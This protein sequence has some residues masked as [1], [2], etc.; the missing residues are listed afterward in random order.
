MKTIPIVCAM[1]MAL[2]LLSGCGDSGDKVKITPPPSSQSG[3]T[4]TQAG[5][6]TAV[7]VSTDTGA[8]TSTGTATGTGLPP[9]PPKEDWGTREKLGTGRQ[10]IVIPKGW[11]ETPPS[12]NMRLRQAK[13]PKAEGD[14]EETEF[15]IFGFQNNAGGLDANSSRW[16]KQFGGK[17]AVKAE[18]SVKCGSGAPVSILELEGRYD[19]GM[20]GGEI[21]PICKMIAGYVDTSEGA[22]VFK[23]IG[24]P[25]TVDAHK[26]EF[27]K[28]IGSFK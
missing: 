6:G 19:A 25:K 9:E 24:P 28:V 7:A 13:V 15:V 27:D 10:T 2:L 22:R 3:Q 14:T 20:G 21:K 12:S 18:R 26:A 8:A 4:A 17:D 23:I 5:T 11:D 16:I 1:G